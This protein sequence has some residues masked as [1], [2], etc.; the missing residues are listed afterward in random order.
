MRKRMIFIA[1]VI[2]A[3]AAMLYV[4][5]AK[6]QGAVVIDSIGCSLFDG[7]GAIVGADSGRAVVTP[8]GNGTLVCKVKGVANSTGSAVHYDFASTGIV[9]G[10]PA[11]I[12]E[13]WHETVSASGNAT[14]V[15]SVK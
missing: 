11:G 14:I 4:E 9:C 8:S 12:T 10:T 2:V 3:A 5:P 1:G 6:T 13:N 7:D 15:C